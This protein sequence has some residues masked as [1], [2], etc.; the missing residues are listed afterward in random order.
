M[1][2][3]STRRLPCTTTCWA[4]ALPAVATEVTAAP[5]MSP[6]TSK[7]A[8]PS[9][10]T[11]PAQSLMRT[12][13]LF[14]SC[15]RPSPAAPKRLPTVRWYPVSGSRETTSR[16]PLLICR[17]A[18]ARRTR[19]RRHEAQ[20]VVESGVGHQHQDDGEAD[21][22]AQFLGAF[23]QRPAADGLDPV[24]QKVT[25]IEQRDGEQIQQPDRHGQYR[26]EMNQLIKTQAC[27]LPRDAGDLDHAAD[28][29]G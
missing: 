9:L 15:R 3:A 20:D 16:S 10:R 14:C 28:L 6:P 8:T 27:N 24:E 12:A 18:V 4:A 1:V 13:P 25:A 17:Q 19:S 26:R 29:V 11:A 21:A 2:L 23:G 7:T 22:E 5:T